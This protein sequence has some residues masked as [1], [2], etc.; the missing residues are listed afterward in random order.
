MDDTIYAENPEPGIRILVLNQ[1]RKKN[2]ISAPMMV[3]LGEL[4]RDA[5]ADPTVRVVVLRGAGE[6]F[7]SGGDLSQ[8]PADEV[9]IE[10][11]RATLRP[12]LAV[13]SQIRRMAT[14]VIA[15]A[16]GF[17]VGGAF[18]LMLASDL[19][20][21]SDRVTVVP[22]FCRIGIVPEMGLAKFLPQLVGDK[23]AKEILF[24]DR[25]LGA[26]ELSQLGLVNRVFPAAELESGTLELARQ[27]AAMPALSV[28]IT[29][30]M[31]NGAYDVGLDAMLETESTASP[32]C[33][34]T[35]AFRDRGS[36]KKQP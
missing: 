6:H 28:Q 27:V 26:S 5:D 14:P 25:R 16:D 17:A 2:A 3:R 10:N 1:P 36:E 11:T 4:L 12:Y 22:A 34:Q 33:A 9:T 32:F 35:A 18:S 19:A 15:M 8:T 23:L 31:I 13:I 29:K 7:S 21:V 30:S 24:T 20:C